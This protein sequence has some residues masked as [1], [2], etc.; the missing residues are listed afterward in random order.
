MPNTDV[1]RLDDYR[2]R[3]RQRWLR[4]TALYAADSERSVIA[5]QLRRA[6]AV[7]GGDRAAAVWVDEYGPGMVHTHTVVD[8]A[9]DR[10][11]RAFAIEPLRAAWQS[12]VPGILD[13]IGDDGAELAGR[14][15]GRSMAC[16]ALGSDGVRSWFLVVDALT[17]RP[18]L[19]AE[20]SGDLMFVAGECASI[21]LHRDLDE[22]RQDRSRRGFA[23][24]PVLQDVE[25]VAEDDPLAHRITC[26]FLVARAVRLFLDDDL[27]A[28]L[29]T[30][31]MQVDGVR[32]EMGERYDDDAE[33]DAW[34]AALQ[35]LEERDR[36]AL[37]EAVLAVGR[38]AQRFGHWSGACELYRNAYEVAM[39]VGAAEEALS[40]ARSQADALRE[41]VKP[42]ESRRWYEVAGRLA[43]CVGHDRWVGPSLDGGPELA[44]KVERLRRQGFISPSHEL[45]NEVDEALP[46]G[47]RAVSRALLGLGEELEE[48][49]QWSAAEEI[50]R[51]AWDIVRSPEPGLE[52]A[53]AARLLGR[54]NRGQARFDEAVEWYEMARELTRSL[55][56]TALETLVV[57]GLGNVASDRG[58]YPEARRMLEE[59]LQLASR[60]G[61]REAVG[62][63]NQNAMYVASAA[64]DN[65]AAVRYGWRAVQSFGDTEE[66][67]HALTT[68]AGVFLEMG[69][70]AA[71]EDACEVVIDRVERRDY[72]LYALASYAHA[73]ALR[74]DRDVFEARRQRLDDQGWLEETPMIVAQFALERGQSYRT[75]GELDEARRWMELASSRAEEHG[76]SEYVIKSEQALQSLSEAAAARADAEPVPSRTVGSEMERIREEV[77][78]YRESLVGAEA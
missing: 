32:A 20:A 27:V 64:G 7:V 8:L 6:I 67:R 3:R 25:D 69:E 24:W 21:L 16:V 78:A 48:R 52:G 42:E 71:A 18:S 39:R 38:H 68:L 10:P 75:L 22:E 59:G 23:G 15:G 58:D 5:E 1:L 34:R 66:S 31:Q 54:V 11:R 63:V 26:R 2:D 41:L 56:E 65:R 4:A 55:G 40:A 51:T 29:E 60:S 74:G 30:L 36:P 47:E 19:D 12:G 37:A 50:Y 28:D 35:A 72:R 17:P 76:L 46:R 53:E 9:C 70:L 44:R 73:A 57:C 14:E 49:A 77:S 43:R 61:D 13:V 33:G 45:W 62:Q